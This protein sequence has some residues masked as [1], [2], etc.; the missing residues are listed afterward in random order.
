MTKPNVRTIVKIA[1]I[2]VGI[3][4]GVAIVYFQGWATFFCS[5]QPQPLTCA[6]LAA[7]GPGDNAYVLLTDAYAPATSYVYKSRTRDEDGPYE[8]V[9]TAIIEFGGGWHQKAYEKYLQDGDNYRMPAPR[10]VRILARF[11]NVRSGEHLAKKL[12]RDEIKGV[13][14][15]AFSPMSAED[16]RLVDETYPLTDPDDCWVIEADLRPWPMALLIPTIVAAVGFTAIGL[17]MAIRDDTRRRRA[18]TPPPTPEGMPAA[19]PAPAA[20]PTDDASNPYAKID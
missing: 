15:N 1:M 9:Y 12:D 11:K 4:C 10:K 20:G 5:P 16:K 6:E 19:P 7:N 18:K 2:V 13:I 8:Y 14:V 3:V 17:G